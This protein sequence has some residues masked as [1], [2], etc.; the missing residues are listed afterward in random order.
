MI[1]SIIMKTHGE[2][3]LYVANLE[4][5]RAMMRIWWLREKK[6]FVMGRQEPQAGLALWAVTRLE[7]CHC[8]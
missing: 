6:L 3:Y 5:E 2:D 8:D 1:T 4:M 7:A